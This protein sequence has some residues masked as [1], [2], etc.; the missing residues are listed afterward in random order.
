[1]KAYPARFQLIA[2]MNPC[3]CGYFGDSTDRYSVQLHRSNAIVAK[4]QPLLIVH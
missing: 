4:S 1:M 3:P 2:A